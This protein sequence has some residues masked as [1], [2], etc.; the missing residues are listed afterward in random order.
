MA[1]TIGF[2]EFSISLSTS[3]RPGDFGGFAPKVFEHAE[4]GDSV[5]LVSDETSPGDLPGMLA[6]KAIVTSRGAPPNR[7]RIRAIAAAMQSA[8]HSDG[9]PPPR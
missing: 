2:G 1:A 7:L 6:A 5:V 3:C 9:V 4:K 8:R